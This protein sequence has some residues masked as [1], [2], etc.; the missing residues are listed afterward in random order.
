MPI[1]SEETNIP[2][3]ALVLEQRHALS[4]NITC[5]LMLD[6]EQPYLAIVG[7]GGV[8]GRHGRLPH[9]AADPDGRLPG[10]REPGV[11]GWGKPGDLCTGPS[12]DRS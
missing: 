6:L 2:H 10:R 9:A 3:Y 5:S 1:L 7:A 4:G 8:P 11:S 12:S